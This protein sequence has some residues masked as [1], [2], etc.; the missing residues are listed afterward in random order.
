MGSLALALALGLSPPSAARWC[1]WA[2]GGNPNAKDHYTDR[3]THG[4]RL[5]RI[6]WRESRHNPLVGIHVRD[7]M[8]SRRSWLGQVKLGH[9]DPTCQPYVDGMWSTR[10]PFGLNAAVHW[11]YLPEC[12]QP[13]IL[14]I[15]FVSAL[16]AAKKF[17]RRCEDAPKTGWC[18]S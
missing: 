18:K 9:L 8:L 12:Y 13:E 14:D 5:E 1:L 17:K 2:I 16:V 10:G 6:S 15:V 4:D 3:R 11:Q 7:A